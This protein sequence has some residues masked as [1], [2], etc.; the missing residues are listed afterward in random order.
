[1]L[2]TLERLLTLKSVSLFTETPDEVLLEIATL[3]NEVSVEAGELIFTEGDIGTSMF[4]VVSGRVHIFNQRRVISELGPR[5]VFGEMAL[6]DPEPRAASVKAL[7][8]TLL[9][10]IDHRPFYEL[11]ANRREIATAI[12]RG[13]SIIFRNG[14]ADLDP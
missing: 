3:L 9:L 7:E 11:M 8:D 14:V 4:I 1:M 12:L 5:T 10:R 6:L 13:I 2:S